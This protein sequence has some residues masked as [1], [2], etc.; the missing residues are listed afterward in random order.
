[1]T[2]PLNAVL[3]YPFATPPGPGEVIE[4]APGIF[5]LRMPLPFALDHINLWLIEEDDGWTQIDCG[6]GTRETRALWER[7]FIRDAARASDQSDYSPRTAIPTTS[8]MRPGFPR[9]SA[10]SY[11]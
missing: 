5:W 8:A 10:A 9:A 6:Y 4:V 1:M 3:D 7:H 2:A 11:P